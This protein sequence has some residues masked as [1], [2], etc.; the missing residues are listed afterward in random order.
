[1]IAAPCDRDT[2]DITSHFLRLSHPRAAE[3]CGRMIRRRKGHSTGCDL[4]GRG[5]RRKDEGRPV[6][7]L[8]NSCP[9]TR[10]PG[11]LRQDSVGAGVREGI[12]AVATRARRPLRPTLGILGQTEGRSRSEANPVRIVLTTYARRCTSGT[13]HRS[14]VE[15]TRSENFEARTTQWQCPGRAFKGQSAVWR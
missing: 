3:G 1:M 6:S 14:Q 11:M 12:H 15:R 13:E 2:F 10:G 8:P 5:S 7:G 9:R 4:P